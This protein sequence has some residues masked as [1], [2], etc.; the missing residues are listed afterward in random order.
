[1]VLLSKVAICQVSPTGVEP[2]TFGSGGRRS[3]RLSYGDAIPK[4]DDVPLPAGTASALGAAQAILCSAEAPTACTTSCL[5]L[6]KRPSG[7]SRRHFITRG[8]DE[9]QAGSAALLGHDGSPR[10]RL[11]AARRATAPAITGAVHDSARF[12]RERGKGAGRG[13]WHSNLS[14]KRS[15]RRQCPSAQDASPRAKRA[16]TAATGQIGL[17]VRRVSRAA[18]QGSLTCVPAGLKTTSAKPG[19]GIRARPELNRPH[20]L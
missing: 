5:W 2:V 3:I 20:H 15:E 11:S 19:S 10:S 8:S 18:C 16:T 4:T 13:V 1:M 9:Q 12:L 6:K 17:G 7:T 14:P